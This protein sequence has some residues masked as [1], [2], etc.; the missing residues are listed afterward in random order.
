M[1]G[2]QHSVL[3]SC[4][5]VLNTEGHDMICECTLGNVENIFVLILWVDPNLIVARESIYEG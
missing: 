3:I 4:V 2:I 5:S 1:K